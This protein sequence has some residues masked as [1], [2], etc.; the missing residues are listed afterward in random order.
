MKPDVLCFNNIH[1]MEFTVLQDCICISFNLTVYS[2]KNILS[3]KYMQ[4][5]LS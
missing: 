5:Y 1:F 2:C 3:L 4:F